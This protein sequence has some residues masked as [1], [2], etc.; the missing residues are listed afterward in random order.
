MHGFLCCLLLNFPYIGTTR[1]N[2]DADYYSYPEVPQKL[3]QTNN[4]SPNTYQSVALESMNYT[5]M[6]STL[7]PH[8]REV[9]VHT[10]ERDGLV[11]AVADSSRVEPPHQYASLKYT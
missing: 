7:D 11:Y 5:S 10:T 1:G 6:Y 4:N 3:T 9:R 2:S 8:K